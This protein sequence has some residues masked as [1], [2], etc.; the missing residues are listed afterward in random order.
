VTDLFDRVA[1][2]ALGLGLTLRP[3][4]RSRFEPETD[5]P[6]DT[7]ESGIWWRDPAR[8]A[9]ASP[10]PLVATD[11]VGPSAI[12]SGPA[13]RAREPE[14]NRTRIS[15]DPGSDGTANARPAPGIA[16]PDPLSESPAVPAP[17]RNVQPLAATAA[18]PPVLR[19]VIPRDPD[20]AP[21]READ[22]D[23]GPVPVDAPRIPLPGQPV[24]A[25][26]RSDPPPARDAARVTRPGPILENT[27]PPVRPSPPAVPF[28]RAPSLARPLMEMA[29]LMMPDPPPRQE[30]AETPAP[31]MP[32]PPPRRESAAERPSPLAEDR[33]EPDRRSPQVASANRRPV[34]TKSPPPALGRLGERRSDAGAPPP[35]AIEITIGR[36]EI[37][38]EPTV[39]PRQGKPFQPHLDLAAYRAARERGPEERGPGGRGQ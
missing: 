12:D 28:D 17:R 2:Q 14:A 4:V 36:L 32:E 29:A 22:R 23:G 13:S 25:P 35:P 7:P 19:N 34:E 21:P 6:A 27:Q 38:G 30:S 20:A 18:T 26:V 8:L 31:S 11:P 39:P 10:P 5:M 1:A 37:R 16:S 9:D 15:A 33:F 24:R 3:R